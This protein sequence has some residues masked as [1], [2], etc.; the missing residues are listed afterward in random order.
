MAGRKVVIYAG[1]SIA[2]SVYRAADCCIGS[3][4]WEAARFWNFKNEMILLELFAGIHILSGRV[5]LFLEQSVTLGSVCLH[6]GSFHSQQCW[7]G[8]YGC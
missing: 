4:V 3:E 7:A 2:E 8:G 5:S 6:A 1:H